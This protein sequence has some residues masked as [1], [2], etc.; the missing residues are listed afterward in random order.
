MRIKE[1]QNLIHSVAQARS[2]LRE[3][4][5]GLTISAIASREDKSERAIRMTLSL[6]FLDPKLVKAVMQGTLPR[7]VSARRLVDAPATWSAQW[8]TIGMSRL[9]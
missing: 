2:W 8:Q 4:M 5:H 1:Q 9:A 7:G 3:V 6:A